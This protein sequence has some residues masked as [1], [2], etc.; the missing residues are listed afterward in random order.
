MDRSYRHGG[1]SGK[2]KS[3]SHPPPVPAEL[4]SFCTFSVVLSIHRRSRSPKS[5][6]RDRFYFQLLTFD[7]RLSSLTSWRRP[8]ARCRSHPAL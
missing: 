8:G 7:F 6:V 1:P 3:R 2:R 4:F 5:K